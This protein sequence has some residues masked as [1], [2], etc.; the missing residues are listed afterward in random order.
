MAVP[1][2][3]AVGAYDHVRDVLDGTV[4]VPGVELIIHAQL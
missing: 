3:L 4:R 2:T 1:L